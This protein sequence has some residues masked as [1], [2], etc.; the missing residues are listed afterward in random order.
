[1]AYNAVVS[2]PSSETTEPDISKYHYKT[3]IQE[4]A[5]SNEPLY[6]SAQIT[7]HNDSEA[8]NLNLENKTGA[9]P[10][11]TTVPVGEDQTMRLQEFSRPDGRTV[12]RLAGEINNVVIIVSSIDENTANREVAVNIS[13]DIFVN[14]VDQC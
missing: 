3:F 7:V 9:E 10:I 2:V 4:D 11:D 6:F 8:A 12:V 5:G 1:M 13:K 14:I